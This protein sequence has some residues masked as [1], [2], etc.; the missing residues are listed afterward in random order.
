M[1]I[2]FYYTAAVITG[3]VSA[4]RLTRLLVN[5]DWPPVVK[6]RIAWDRLTKDGPWSKLA[7]CPWCAAPYISAMILL[8][9]VASNL[10]WTW[11][12]FN[13]WLAGSYAASWIVFHDEDGGD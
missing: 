13:G 5:D 6:A 10:H 8:W 3:I 12:I 2:E 1:R 11:W 9:G 4:G 7:H